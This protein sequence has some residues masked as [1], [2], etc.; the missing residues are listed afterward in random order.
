MK[1]IRHAPVTVDQYLRDQIGKRRA[2]TPVTFWV[3]DPT[4]HCGISDGP[5]THM[6]VNHGTYMR[7]TT[8]DWHNDDSNSEKNNIS[9]DTQ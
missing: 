4:D 7:Q 8:G 5:Y 9:V 2:Q 6:Y 1:H 3:T